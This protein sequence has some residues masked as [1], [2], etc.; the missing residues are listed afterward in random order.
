[1]DAAQLER[2]G[3]KWTCFSCGV[4]FY[5]FAKPQAVCPRCTSD[6]SLAPPPVAAT[7][8]PKRKP[9]KPKIK[10]TYRS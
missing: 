1:M 9:A 8:R 2:F 6:Q 3:R 10:R 4:R 5:D 7:G